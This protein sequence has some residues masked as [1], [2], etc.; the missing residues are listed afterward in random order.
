MN[1][2][3]GVAEV[4]ARDSTGNVMH[5]WGGPGGYNNFTALGSLVSASD[6]F[7]WTLNNGDAEVFAVDSSGDLQYIHR[8]GGTWGA[9]TS[10]G[11]GIDACAPALSG[12][13]AG[14]VSGP[15]AGSADAGRVMSDAG[16]ARDAGAT[17]NDAGKSADSGSVVADS[18]NDIK[19]IHAGCGCG[20]TDA[21]PIGL[22][23]LILVT[24]IMRRR[25]AV[26]G[27]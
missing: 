21:S 19:T 14:P 8:T 12:P 16:T 24:G 18:G 15:D 7:G 13:D 1:P 10:I 3:S 22:A 11:S 20:A 9:W 27:Q 6:P 26:R 23:G 2:G 25:R 17:S 5:L 4:F